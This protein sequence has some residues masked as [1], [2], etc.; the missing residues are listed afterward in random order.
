MANEDEWEDTDV[1]ENEETCEEN[2]NDDQTAV[3][4]E[5]P[6]NDIFSLVVDREKRETYLKMSSAQVENF[7]FCIDF[8][9]RPQITYRID[10]EMMITRILYRNMIVSSFFLNELRQLLPTTHKYRRY[11][12]EIWD[13]LEDEV[14]RNGATFGERFEEF[15][16]HGW[17][18]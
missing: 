12:D 6:L 9:L 1:D 13:D 15:R 7:L 14:Q 8:L 2:E 4:E 16:E 17:R 3:E 18:I 11:L 10:Q 5:Q